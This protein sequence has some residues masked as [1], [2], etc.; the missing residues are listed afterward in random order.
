MVLFY[1]DCASNVRSGD[2]LVRCSMY[3]QVQDLVLVMATIDENNKVIR[4]SI[5]NIE[6]MDLIP[7]MRHFTKIS[8]NQIS[9]FA[10]MFKAFQKP[11]VA[12]AVISFR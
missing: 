7:Y 1:C 3:G 9:L 8:G 4:K 5:Y 2:Q 11:D 10:K 12:A 6:E